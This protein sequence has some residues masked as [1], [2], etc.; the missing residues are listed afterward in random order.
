M[1]EKGHPWQ[2]LVESQ[3]GIQARL[4]EYHWKRCQTVE[5]AIEFHRELI[6]DHNRLPHFAH[7]FRNDQ[8]HAPLE[9]LGAVKGQS[10]EPAVLHQT[11]SRKFWQRKTDARGFVR[12]GRWKIYIEEALPKTQA[13]VHYWEGKLR[14]ECDAQLI[15]EYDCQWDNQKLR[16][17]V[18][19]N[20]TPRAHPFESKQPTLFDPLWIGDPIEIGL[21]AT[22]PQKKPPAP[23]RQ[24]RLYLGP[25][26]VKTA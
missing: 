3:L 18:I 21:G 15:T 10:V 6:R 1:Y 19:S 8:K 5:A 20:P 24:L 2:N 9:V 14:A 12:V 11:F 25:E 22:L 16:P 26:L 13:Q 4:G 23:G 17:K 7:R